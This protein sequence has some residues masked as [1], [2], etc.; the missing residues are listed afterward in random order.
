M[1]PRTQRAALK[2]LPR[3]SLIF[4][5]MAAFVAGPGCYHYRVMPKNPD[6]GDEVHPKKTMHSFLWGLAQSPPNGVVTECTEPDALAE[7]AMTTNAGYLLL[8]VVTL[9]I[10]VP[11]EVEWQCAP[12]PPMEGE[13]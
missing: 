10:W 13:I 1:N 12:P 11:M 5:L 9:G 8:S 4:V 2:G 6:P 7:V 3:L